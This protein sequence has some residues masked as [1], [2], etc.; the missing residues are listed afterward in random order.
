[1]TPRIT[2]TGVDASTALQDIA[3]LLSIAPEVEI[4]FLF[5]ESPEGRQ[6]YPSHAW[7]REAMPSARG[8]CALHVCGSGG[9]RLLAEGQLADLTRNAARIQV[10]GTVAA[11]HFSADWIEGICALHPAHTIIT[12]HCPGN[13]ALLDV[14]AANHALL[15]DGS[16]GNGR[17]PEA[18]TRP[19]TDKSVG[20][21]GGLG[22]HN[23]A[24]ELPLIREAAGST[25]YWIDMEGRIRDVADRFDV[26]AAAAA[27]RFAAGFPA[28]HAASAAGSNVC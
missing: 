6:R 4:G 25:P 18:W 20:F 9:R 12:Q 10:N 1:M 15:V 14:A 2:V 3:A 28:N 7:L 22:P 27:I 17:S 16:G 5:T 24:S 13:V 26:A 8:R 19:A 23:L 11:G 21:A